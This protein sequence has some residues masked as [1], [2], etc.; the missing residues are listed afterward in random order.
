ML[1]PEYLWSVADPVVNIWEELNKWALM[2]ICERIVEADLYNFNALPGTARYRAWLLEQSGMHYEK[3][4]TVISALT[5]K[6]EEEVKRLFEEAG[7]LALENDAPVYEQHGI[8]IPPLQRNQS[9][10]RILN[11]SYV[12]T[13]GE[14]RNYTRTTLDESNKQ[15]INALDKSYVEVSSGM[16]SYSEVIKE[17]VDDL[18][19]TGTVVTYPT[20]HKDS[21]ETAVRRA[22]LTGINQGT[23]KMTLECAIQNGYEY[24]LVDAHI[25]ARVNDEDKIANH[26]GWQGK[27]YKIKGSDE[28]Y[29]N[30]EEETGFPNN[31][32]GLGGY[33]C[34]H[35]I[36]PHILGDPNTWEKNI[37]D[38]EE[39]KKVYE[40][41]QKQRY[42]ERK[43]RET[44]RNLLGLKTCIEH[45]PDEKTKFDLQLEYNKRAAMLQRQNQRYNE[46][47][48]KNEL[49]P[50]QERL[51]AAGWNRESSDNA[52]S[53]ANQYN[54]AKIQKIQSGAKS[55]IYGKDVYFDENKSYTVNVP[56]FSD[57][58]NYAI[59]SAAKKVAEFGSKTRYEYSVILDLKTGL[60]VDF[61]T[62]KERTSISHYYKYLREHPD[63]RYAMIHNH[64]YHTGLSLPDIQELSNWE[65]MEAIVSVSNDGYINVAISNGVKTTEY[66]YSKYKNER[67][68]LINGGSST[69]EAE[70]AI[71]DIAVNAYVKGGIREYE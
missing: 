51:K 55:T 62:S 34:R 19:K 14:M 47:C 54:N 35:H 12:Q 25:G 63:G 56:E 7:L 44:K 21:I 69:S 67:W 36:Y 17:T 39:N 33:N 38:E 53:G 32:L 68:K 9:L 1:T 52:R 30:L 40:L 16:R 41:S 42:M 26:A 37:P 43:I 46:F 3:M 8:I 64:N 49:R 65:N 71:V 31:P 28:N 66:L 18:A 6:S 59:S 29:G 13:N 48:E 57:S 5:K 24:V 45:C 4:I 11:N 23:M 58:V 61:G 10:L 70:R 20:G 22:V 50:E 15:C 2:D 60:E 27:I